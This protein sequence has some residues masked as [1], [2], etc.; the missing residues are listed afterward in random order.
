MIS[1][2]DLRLLL[3]FRNKFKNVFIDLNIS[4]PH[5][6]SISANLASSTGMPSF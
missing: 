4:L 6:I 5:A 1:V 2:V 3:V